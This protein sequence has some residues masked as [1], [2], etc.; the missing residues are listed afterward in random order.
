[1]LSS[2]SYQICRNAN[3]ENCVPA[4][5]GA[6]VAARPG[7]S[8][9]AARASFPAV[10]VA[11][12][13][14]ACGGTDHL[15]F[16]RIQLYGFSAFKCTESIFNDFQPKLPPAAGNRNTIIFPI[17]HNAFWKLKIRFW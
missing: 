8:G 17:D 7:G 1:M 15:L 6:L 13:L 4:R 12:A 14:A 5:A 11:E 10:D 2:S 16:T 3:L 9:G